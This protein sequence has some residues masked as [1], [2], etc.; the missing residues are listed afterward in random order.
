MVNS[1]VIPE[2]GSDTYCSA[3]NL[4]TVKHSIP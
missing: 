2:R 3:A 1:M 4:Q